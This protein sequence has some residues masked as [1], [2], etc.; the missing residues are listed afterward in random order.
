MYL[1]FV[2]IA[3]QALLSRGR[4]GRGHERSLTQVLPVGEV[5]AKPTVGA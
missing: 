4:R 3:V 2:A 1:T 5:S